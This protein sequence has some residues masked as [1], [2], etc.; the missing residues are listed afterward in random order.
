[1]TAQAQNIPSDDALNTPPPT[2]RRVL[3]YAA[4][5]VGLLILLMTG[6]RFASDAA[7]EMETNT[8]S[9]DRARLRSLRSSAPE[10]RP[11]PVPVVIKPADAA[12]QAALEI[13]VR[14]QLQAIREQD[15]KKALTYAVSSISGST[16][17]DSFGDMIRTRYS[18]MLSAEKVFIRPAKLQT[19]Q[20]AAPQALVETEIKTQAGGTVRYGY[21][22]VESGNG[23]R[24]G[25]VIPSG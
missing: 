24:V 11:T 9:E 15:F 4:A 21:I 12:T 14:G 23:W 16:R 19:L 10:T 3:L 8:A 25:G 1:M 18:G 5:P 20:G 13:V 22:L 6:V 7:R 2:R 17:P